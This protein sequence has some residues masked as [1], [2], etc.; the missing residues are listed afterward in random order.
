MR[1]GLAFQY[2]QGLCK[3]TGEDNGVTGEGTTAL[4]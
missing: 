2:L 4:N 1:D 3:K